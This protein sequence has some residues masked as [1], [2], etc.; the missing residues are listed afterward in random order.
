MEQRSDL[1]CDRFAN[2]KSLATPHFRRSYGLQ[3]L[4]CVSL[5]HVNPAQVFSDCIHAGYHLSVN[6]FTE[7]GAV[8]KN[9]FFRSSPLKSAFRW[10]CDARTPEVCLC[11]YTGEKRRSEIH[12]SS[13]QKLPCVEA[14]RKTRAGEWDR[15]VQDTVQDIVQANHFISVCPRQ[16]VGVEVKA[17]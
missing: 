4:L 11:E 6:V 9:E 14:T 2:E 13:F 10:D 7:L 16:G 3:A 15:C 5:L 8:C 12:R 1:F 17:P